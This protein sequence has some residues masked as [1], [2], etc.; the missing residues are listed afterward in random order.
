MIKKIIILGGQGFVGLNISKY[1]LAKKKNYKLILIGNKT[2]LK[3]IFTKK[4][5]AKLIIHNIDIYE[6]GKLPCEIFRDAIIINAF[7]MTKISFK[8]FKK[9]Y[10]KLCKFLE[11]NSI[12]KLILLSSIS[13]YGK[14]N[15]TIISEKNVVNPISDYGKRCAVAEKI[16]EKFFKKKLITLRIANIFGEYRFKNGTIEKI[17]ANLVTKSKYHLTDPNLK[18]TYINAST[19]VKIISIIIDKNIKKKLLINISN[20]NYIFNF[21]TLNILI[22]KILKKKILYYP[23]NKQ[24]KNNHDSVCI[25]KTFVKKFNYKFINNFAEELFH[26]AKFIKNNKK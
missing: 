8:N 6:V 17:V 12:N 20:P 14:T 25:P 15:K 9:N 10:F 23:K 16:S 22:S 19:L 2:K 26:I 11:K 21:K 13:V 18:R 1:F 5:K 24:I 7:L 3:K 4:E